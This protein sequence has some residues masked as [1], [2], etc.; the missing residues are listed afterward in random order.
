ML[1][2][3]AEVMPTDTKVFVFFSLSYFYTFLNHDFFFVLVP[4]TFVVPT[5]HTVENC[6]NKMYCLK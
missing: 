3:T 1:T 5:L 6:I 4:G 2:S